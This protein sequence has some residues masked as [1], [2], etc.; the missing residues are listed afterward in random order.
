M[1]TVLNKVNPDQEADKPKKC[2][3]KHGKIIAAILVV[4]MIGVICCHVHHPRSIDPKP[5]TTCSVMFRRDVLGGSAL[6]SPRIDRSDNETVTAFGTL[7]AVD[8]EAILL[9]A[10]N[11][12]HFIDGVPQKKQLWIPKSNILLIEYKK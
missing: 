12:I 8:R 9:E 6:V 5:G 1:E 2:T 11:M 3:C 7:I 4:L 10:D